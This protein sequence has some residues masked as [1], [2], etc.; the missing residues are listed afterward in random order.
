M[1][2]PEYLELPSSLSFEELLQHQRDDGPVSSSSGNKGGGEGGQGRGDLLLAYGS[3]LVRKFQNKLGHALWGVLESVYLQAI[4]FH[5]L[6]WAQYCLY[7]LRKRWPESV[8][9]KRL[10][11]LGLESKGK[12]REALSHYDQLLDLHPY[13]TLLRKRIIATLRNQGALSECVEMLKLHLEEL[14]TDMEAWHELGVIFATE[15]YLPEAS[16]CF[17]E[18][19]LHEPSNILFLT[20]YA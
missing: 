15:G 19:L 8:R 2:P 7:R 14:G 5:Q 4:E 3:C 11:G 18:L 9:V 12:W 10:C 1:R 17:E 13:D 6:G 20:I 16:Y